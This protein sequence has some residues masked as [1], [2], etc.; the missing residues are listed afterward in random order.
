MDTP[1]ANPIGDLKDSYGV[2]VI[3]SGYGGAILAGRLAQGRSLC[4]LERGWE[5]IPGTF[6]DE[7]DEVARQVRSE[8]NPVGLYNYHVH[9]EVDVLIGCGLGGTSLINANVVIQPDNDLFDHP[10][11]PDEIRRD[12]DNGNL[13]QYFSRVRD[14]LQAER[15]P[16]TRPSL[17][18][19]EA[20][21][22]STQARGVPFAKLDVAVNLTRYDDQ[23]NHVGIQQHL[24]I[25][26]GDCVTGCNVRAKNTLYMNYLP[27]AKQHGTQI[28]TQVEVDH[29]VKAPGGGYYVLCTYHPGN[30]QPS[31]GRVSRA[32]AVVLATGAPGSTEILLRSR[33][34]GLSLSDTLGQYFSGNGDVLSAGYNTDQQTDV[35]GFGNFRDDRA[36]IRVGP[37]ILSMADYRGRGPLMARFIIEEGAIPRAL[38]DTLRSS[39]PL[40]NLTEGQD[41]DTGDAAEEAR[42]VG[43]D[44]VRY[45]PKGALN[46]SMVYLGIGHDGADGTLVLDDKGRVRLLWGNAPEQPLIQ[47]INA[48][49]KAHTAVLGGTYLQNPRW[50]RSLGRNLVPVHPLGGCSM[51]AD[52]EGG[53]VDHRGRVYDPSRGTKAVHAGLF[54]A[55]G[56]MIPAA[57]GVQPPLD[58][59]CPGRAHRR[60]DRSGCAIGPDDEALRSHD[61]RGSPCPRGSR[62]QRGDERLRRRGHPGGERE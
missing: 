17:A 39:V 62:I 59:L 19:I 18:K 11:W 14:M 41:T 10:R 37:T 46:H 20:H 31:T 16:D 1:L 3:G 55:D 28:F 56:A 49:M 38:V 61:V 57:V 9:D 15:Y 12:W 2:V 54:V 51:G 22:K 42:R 60:P 27:L 33:E 47:T 24:C 36:H 45:D 13:N 35:L 5:W 48:E 26:C 8:L 23:P 32:T 29:L 52:A 30:G 43:R 44:L 4:I 53:V 58:H 7:L 25:L 6:P 34:Y 50:D 40:L 21:A